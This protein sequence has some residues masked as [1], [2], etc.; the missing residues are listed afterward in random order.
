MGL[1]HA[2]GPFVRGDIGL[3]PIPELEVGGGLGM[4][5][6]PSTMTTGPGGS[7]RGCRAGRG[8]LDLCPAPVSGRVPDSGLVSVDGE[9]GPNSDGSVLDLCRWC[10]CRLVN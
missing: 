9:I 1:S 7:R 3:I 2:D 10:E 5:V 6:S 8:G 4:G